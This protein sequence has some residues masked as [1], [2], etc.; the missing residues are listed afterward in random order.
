M[1][2]QAPSLG[3][4]AAMV[5][6]SLSCF[7]ILLYLWL[8]FGGASPLQPQG[9]RFKAAFPEAVLLAE[10]AD[11]NMAGLKVGRVTKK[12]LDPQRKATIVEME[13]ETEFAPI[14][15]DARA[16]L[17][18]KTLLGQTYIEI[19]PGSR[20]AEK[21]EDGG[22]LSRANVEEEVQVDEIVRTFDKPTRR[23]FQGWVRELATVIRDGRG[24]DLNDAFGSLEEF[25]FS[26]SDVLETLDEQKPVVQRLVRNAGIT[27]DALT[28][29]Q[30]QF[31]ELVVNANDFFGALADRNE[32][33][34]D[35][36]AVLP[37]FLTESRA[38]LSRL[39]GFSRTA[40][41]LVRDLKPVAVKLRPTV[42]DVAAL[43]PD[44]KRLFRD[45][46]PLIDESRRTLP[47]AERFLRGAEPVFESLHVYLPE[48]NPI[49]NYLNYSQQQVAD[50]FSNGAATL[51]ATLEPVD[52][53]EGPRHYLRQYT[54][55]GSRAIGIATSRA[56]H[57]RGNSYGA[58]NYLKRKPAFGI[59]E[60]FD[61]KPTGGTKPNPD[62]GTAPCFV[63]PKSV[64][65]GGQFP[66]IDKGEQEVKPPP[67]GRD[68]TGS[69]QP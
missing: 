7:G 18:P 29:R 22:M 27:L 3:R 52:N 46:N 5:I 54:M 33:L 67:Q 37:T 69:A 45:L 49:L 39:E 48:L 65:D 10:T 47:P 55:I 8:S 21:L 50:F 2:K 12:S 35:T 60:A 9:Y 53:S 32:A 25:I 51:N 23:A 59:T 14:S 26:G 11:V 38:T 34:A 31:R 62:G 36:I 44:L 61:C 58:P 40:R 16:I 6:F 24:Q 19:A 43:S 20:S 42:R 57:D 56:N 64:F 4:I 1:Q 15:S 41:P 28:E 17:R 63:Q 68:S 13:L 30:G 66:R